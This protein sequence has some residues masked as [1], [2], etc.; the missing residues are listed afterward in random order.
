MAIT[1]WFANDSI[2][3]TCCSVNGR[4]ANRWTASMPIG[5]P[6]RSSGV[7]TCDRLPMA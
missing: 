5:S 1:A 2:S 7:T 4:S 3:A 6:S